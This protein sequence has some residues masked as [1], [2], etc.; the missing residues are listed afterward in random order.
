[1]VAYKLFLLSIE[2]SSESGPQPPPRD[3]EAELSEIRLSLFMEIEKRKQAEEALDDMRT[4]WSRIRQQLSQV[5]LTLPADPTASADDEQLGVDPAE[6]LCCQVY[7]ARFVSNCIGRGTAK[8]EVEIEMEAQI[9]SK[10]FEISR[11]WDRLHYYE[12][13]NRRGVHV[14]REMSQRNQEAVEMS[15]RLR[16]IRKRRQRWVWG[17]IAAAITLG[18]GALAW[19]YLS[20]G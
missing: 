8:A 20:T 16:Q 6:E 12:T 11:L 9:E 15:R 5:G 14:N 2:L 1:M 7:L 19:S 17:S 13:V 4:R 3:V 18:T 10:N